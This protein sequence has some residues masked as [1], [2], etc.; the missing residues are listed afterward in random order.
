MNLPAYMNLPAKIFWIPELYSTSVDLG[1]WGFRPL[2]WRLF[3]QIYGFR[4][5]S[6]FFF[7]WGSPDFVGNHF[8]RG[9]SILLGIPVF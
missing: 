5:V 4:E 3:A 2:I 6:I 7:F 8:F 9:P 1:F